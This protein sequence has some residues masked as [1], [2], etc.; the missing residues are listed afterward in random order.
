MR[1]TILSFLFSLV[2]YNVSL[3]QTVSTDP[4]FPTADSPFTMTVDVTG[5]SLEGFTGDVWIWTWAANEDNTYK[6]PDAPT[7]VNPATPA[8]SA[9]LV[10][11][12][13]TDPNI[14]TFTMTAADFIGV[15]ASEI[16][17]IGFKLKSQDW[18]DNIQS[19]TDLFIDMSESAF[20]VA[21]QTPTA[22]FLFVQTNDVISISALASIE[23]TF[24]LTVGGVQENEQMG[25]TDYNYDLTVLDI[26]GSQE[27]V[28]TITDGNDSFENSFT[29]IISTVSENEP[30]PAGIIDGI[31]Y[32]S[33]TEVVLS[34]WAPDISS[35]YVIGEFTDW[36]VKPEFQMK[37]D[38]EHFWLSVD[39][40]VSG[41]EY[42]FQY[43]LDESIF[44]ADPYADKIL[45]PDDRFIPKTVYPNLKEFPEEA[46]KTEWYFN[47][48]AVLQTGQVPYDWQVTDFVPPAQEDLVIYEL[49]IRD[50]FE[51]DQIS[52][53]NLIDTLSYLEDLGINAV[54]LMP[55][56]E[57]NGNDSWGYNPTFKFAVDKAYGPKNKFKEFID[58]AHGRG[59][60]VILDIVMN[61]HDVPN[62]YLLLDFDFNNF[63]PNPTNKWFNVTA[64]HPFNVFFDMDHE[65]A[66]TQ[67]YLDTVNHYWLNEYK[68]DGYRYDLSKGFTQN[69][70][71]S[72]DVAAWNQRDESRITLLKRMADDIWSHSP[73][74]YVILEHFADNDEEIELANYG[75]MPWGNMHGAYTSIT[76]GSSSVTTG[77][78]HGTRGWSEPNLVAY[79]ESHDEERLMFSLLNDESLDLK[80]ALER[81]KSATTLFYTIPG[82]KMLWQFGEL[83]YDQSINLCLDGSIDEDC[84][85]GQKPI[86][87]NNV[88]GLDYNNDE[89]RLK[90]FDYMSH[91]ITL[92][93]TYSIFS[94]SDV[95]LT[96]DG[97]SK[98][99]VLK[100]TPFTSSPADASEMNAVILGNFSLEERDVSV[101]F[102][103]TGDWFHYFANGSITTIENANTTF[104]FQ[105]GEVRI[106]TD[107]KLGEVES[108][109][110]NNLPPNAPELVS[111]TEFEDSGVQLTWNDNS[112]IETRYR[113]LR[114]LDGENFGSL[115]VLPADRTS[116]ID[117]DGIESG[118]E[119][120][121]KV[122]A[123]NAVFESESNVISITPNNIVTSLGQSLENALTIFPNPAGDW[124]SIMSNDFS[125]NEEAEVVDLIGNRMKLPLE[126][127]SE[128]EVRIN[129]STLTNG[130]YFLRYSDN[131]NIVRRRFIV[132]H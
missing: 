89:A 97:L 102:P 43:L 82:P 113:V 61:H 125:I 13:S 25:I 112:E 46:L 48:L 122:I 24:T 40:L 6:G 39:G 8:Q 83:G 15:A 54:Q 32:E 80:P 51:N 88:E 90:L 73:N 74:A 64:K 86:P 42:A 55:I 36:T 1:N 99:V 52:Y 63:Q 3:G 77:V 71:G 105:P 44:I 95:E 58:Q 119:Y 4:R 131:G 59:M 101:E 67:T 70:S 62:P 127:I 118:L 103:H 84:R 23:A 33:D 9:A 100:N 114:S 31:N 30:R 7:N 96:D 34:V 49:L 78:Y 109:L 65:S 53:D 117:E 87:W 68:V 14:Y 93:T 19:D 12:S 121:Y 57:F 10:T 11:R 81:I 16:P 2:V 123:Q 129:T 45:D 27:V 37:K 56:M 92:K 76:Q 132:N 41:Q 104:S 106:Y 26:S 111:V 85:V 94:T 124:V 20:N 28:L 91:L 17:R 38:G 128:S 69:D 120:T 108:E 29:Y 66:Y 115:E 18:N 5:T 75:M 22:P 130:V 21:F 116:F 98:T 72:D 107:V 50:F 126:R 79:M 110:S 47:R 60:A 35:A